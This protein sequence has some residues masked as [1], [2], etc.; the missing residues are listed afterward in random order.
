MINRILNARLS[1]K[2]IVFWYGLF[3]LITCAVILYALKSI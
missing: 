3:A 1:F 2:K